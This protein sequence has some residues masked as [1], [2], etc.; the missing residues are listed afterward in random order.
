MGDIYAEMIAVSREIAASFPLPSFYTRCRRWVELSRSLL[1]Q[2]E[3]I[4]RCQAIV[5]QELENNYGHGLDH[6]EKVAIDAGALAYIE[7][8]SLEES[9][10]QQAV[11]LAQTN[12]YRTVVSHRSGETVDSSIA[13]L[14]VAVN[15]GLIKT[16][17]A[18]R[19]ERLA[20]YNRLLEIEEDLSAAAVFA[21]AGAFRR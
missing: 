2:D 7:G 13:D 6:V 5:R 16:G 12:G 10:R 9:A 8:G 17:S 20:K 18:S 11:R 19:G 21:G 15:S 1:S 14:A 4:Q 3:E